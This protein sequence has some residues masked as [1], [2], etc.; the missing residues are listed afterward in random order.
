MTHDKTSGAPQSR[1]MAKLGYLGRVS[2]FFL[3]A[4]FAYPNVFVEGL[5]LTKIQGETQGD[6]YAKK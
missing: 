4:G 1:A 6:L 3:T 5:D 2:V